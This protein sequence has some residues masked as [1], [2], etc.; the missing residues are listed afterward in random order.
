MTKTLALVADA[1]AQ[2]APLSTPATSPSLYPGMEITIAREILPAGAVETDFDLWLR[3]RDQGLGGSEVAAVLG[4]HPYKSAYGVWMDK[5][6][7]G[8]PIRDKY[9]MRRGRYY[10]PTIAQWFADEN[11]LGTLKTG[12]RQRLDEPWMLANPDRF[13]SDGA[14]LEIKLPASEW[15]GLWKDGACLHAVVQCLWGCAVTGLD[16]W[17]LAADVNQG[18]GPELPVWVLNA[19]DWAERVAYWIEYCDWWWHQYVV[20]DMQPPVDGSEATGEALDW[21]YRNS[22][23]GDKLGHMVRVPGLRQLV[24]RRA[25]LKEEI[26]LATDL[27]NGVENRIK[28]ALERDEV[29][30]D[31]DD[32][33][34]I[35]W[36]PVGRDPLDP[37]LPKTRAMREIKPKA[38]RKPRAAKGVLTP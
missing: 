6:G 31:D 1:S 3:T 5:T 4:L 22:N 9:V 35:A 19:D 13:T 27:L 38:P 29:G 23:G 7:R 20:Q 36:R 14:G 12:T 15:S 11:E 28:A 16:T 33:P 26:K 37:S 2:T 8:R 21:A 18:R 10:E 17:Y 25:E 24:T 32:I 30:C 34:I